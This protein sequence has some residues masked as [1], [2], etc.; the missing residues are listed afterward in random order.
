MNVRFLGLRAFPIMA[1]LFVVIA[2]VVFG[3]GGAVISGAIVSVA[4]TLLLRCPRCG[5]SPY[6]RRTKVGLVGFFLPEST[7]SK[8]GYDLAARSSKSGDMT[9]S[10]VE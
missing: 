1:M 7:C 2:A 10:N 5:K 8:C 9:Q 4:P 6:I 3:I